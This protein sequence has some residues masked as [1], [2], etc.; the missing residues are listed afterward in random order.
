[1]RF[2]C[3]VDNGINLKIPQNSFDQIGV[4]NISLYETVAV[5]A[6]YISKIFQ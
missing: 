4:A 6:I 3:K 2:R 5:R 1:M